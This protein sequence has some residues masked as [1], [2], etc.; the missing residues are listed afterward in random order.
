MDI[1]QQTT[2]AAPL[3]RGIA[4]AT[5]AAP[6][7]LSFSSPLLDPGAGLFVSALSVGWAGLAGGAFSGL[8]PRRHLVEL[9]A[10]DIVHAHREPM[11]A[12]SL[13]TLW[14]V[15]TGT[16]LGPAG[17]DGLVAGFFD[18]G[19]VN[20][21]MSAAWW[22]LTGYTALKLRKVIAKPKKAK[23]VEQMA[24]LPEGILP[25]AIC[26]VWSRYVSAPGGQHPGQELELWTHSPER[27]TGIVRAPMGKTASVRAQTV[28]SLYRVPL[29][30]VE[31]TPGTH[32][33]EM[34]I[35]VSLTPLVAAPESAG[36]AGLW[37][38]RAAR[39]GGVAPGTHLEGVQYDKTT[40]GEVAFVVADDDTDSL[41]KVVD[42]RDL[43][44]ALRTQQ[45]LVSYEPSSD[46]RRA[47][48][49]LMKE[50]PLRR[51][52]PLEGLDE[53]MWKGP[54]WFSLGVAVSGR[55]VRT[56]LL[57]FKVDEK[58]NAGGGGAKH[59]LVSGVTGSGKGGVLQLVA[60]SAHLNKSVILYADPKGSSNPA[61]EPMAAHCGKGEDGAMGTLRVLDK[62]TDHRVELTGR[63]GQKNF[64]VRKMP[65]VTCILDEASMLLGAGAKHLAEAKQIVEKVT[66]QGR[67]I[68]IS[69]VLANQIIQLEQLGGTSAIRDNIVGGG[70]VMMLRGDSSQ[71][72]LIDI[73]G[74]EGCDPSEI[75]A[76]WKGDEMVLIY[77][78]NATL[79]DP[80]PTFGLGYFMTAD[81]ICSMARSYVLEDASP[82]VNRDLV[83]VPTDW[84]D[85][86]LHEEIASQGLDVAEEGVEY[87]ATPAKTKAQ[88]AEDKILEALLM[89]D[90]ME[91]MPVAE[92]A[93]ETGL[94]EQTV[95]NTIRRM[96][97]NNAAERVSKGRYRASM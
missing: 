29:E 58:G 43:A 7:A 73:E 9:P 2:V 85:W 94:A 72:S 1:A 42:R 35:A 89:A 53:L 62:L 87:L 59:M 8:I 3:E 86:H 95:Q 45:V 56:Q 60:L 80:E 22:S 38:K 77:D 76:S 97:E 33:G 18:L 90:P 46:P 78:E 4:V 79:V 55:P 84:P 28:S 24:S 83:Q 15:V 13:G 82:Y 37:S 11:F 92:I 6:F 48:V 32:E 69:M 23:A 54:G 88:N 70:S 75:P 44:G 30:Q 14:G 52:K 49:R 74:M 51:G 16:T 68:G 63:T 21:I 31:L 34:H 47:V 41:P 17:I 64:D 67:S 57:D 39:K 20:G 71:K 36:L 91:G 40:G 12:A 96:V 93:S 19:S 27:W 5:I 61:I 50:N 10:G 25:N 26:Q 65:H 66:K 81:K